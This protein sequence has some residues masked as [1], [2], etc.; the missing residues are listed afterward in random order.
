MI[1]FQG[2]NNDSIRTPLDSFEAVTLRRNRN[3]WPGDPGYLT[4]VRRNGRFLQVCYFGE[5]TALGVGA[6]E[7][8]ERLSR[9]TGLPLAD[10]PPRFFSKA[11][12]VAG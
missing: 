3:P 6:R 7:L 8:A 1:S 5:K 12:P 4:L 9:A 2:V 11:I 10:Y